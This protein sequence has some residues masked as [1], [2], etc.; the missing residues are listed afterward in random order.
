MAGKLKALMAKHTL[1][2]TEDDYEAVMDEFVAFANGHRLKNVFNIP[3]GRQNVD[4]YFDFGE[5]DCL[6]ELKQTRVYEKDKT[7]DTYFNG[8][9]AAG[10]LRLPHGVGPGSAMEI[11]P[12]SLSRSEWRRFY[13]KF[14]PSILEHLDKANN[15]LRDTDLWL[16]HRRPWRVKAAF[17]LNSGD[18]NLPT[19]LLA[20]IIEHKVKLEWRIARFRNLDLTMCA[21]I[22][23]YRSGEHPLHSH[24][25]VRTKKIRI[26]PMLHGISK[27]SGSVIRR[28]NST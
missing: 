22:D 11:G 20:R 8:L 3:E 17:I 15:Q 5:F 1:A 16:E 25:L 28:P 10:R 6:L 9:I 13:K 24:R 27:T 14:R 4:Y 23:M 26:K 12:N 21:A 19:D 7:V 2:R 18:Y